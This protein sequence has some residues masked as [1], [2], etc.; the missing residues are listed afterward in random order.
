MNQRWINVRRAG[1]LVCMAATALFGA[2]ARADDLPC[3]E[4]RGRAWNLRNGGYG[5]QHRSNRENR[6]QSHVRSS[7]LPHSEW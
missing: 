4:A 7:F 2:A 5:Q 1:L 3:I 6:W